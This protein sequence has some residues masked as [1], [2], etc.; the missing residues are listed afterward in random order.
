V[1]IPPNENLDD[2]P[3]VPQ[4][5]F[6]AGLVVPR[7]K[8]RGSAGVTPAEKARRRHSSITYSSEFEKE[9]EREREKFEHV[10][11]GGA[12]YAVV[13]K[14]NSKKGAPNLPE[15]GASEKK[16]QRIRPKTPSPPSQ[17]RG[18]IQLEFQN[19]VSNLRSQKP[20][21]LPKKAVFP[22]SRTKWDYSTVVF[23][24]DGGKEKEREFENDASGD[25]RKKPLPPPPPPGSKSSSVSDSSIVAPPPIPRQQKKQQSLG[26]IIQPN[27]QQSRQNHTNG[28][29]SVPA[30]SQNGG[31]KVRRELPKLPPKQESPTPPRPV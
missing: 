11:V 30:P 10:T 24:T 22:E 17:R 1:K 28:E 31:G 5:K 13:S 23:D 25:K 20:P 7:G 19:G 9:Q 15:R 29:L 26:D 3:P 16:V 21:P 14:P 8:P 27:G 4:R 18:Y 6:D 2:P 12:M